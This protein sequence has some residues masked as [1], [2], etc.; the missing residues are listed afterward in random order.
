MDFPCFVLYFFSI[1]DIARLGKIRQIYW[2][3]RIEISKICQV[4]KLFVENERVR[5]YSSSKSPTDFTVICMVGGG[6]KLVP[7]RIT[8]PGNFT[9]FKALFSVGRRFFPDW[10]IGVKS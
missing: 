10:S 3:Q 9:T 6:H 7:Y 4:L 5:R 1:F 8:F 2:K